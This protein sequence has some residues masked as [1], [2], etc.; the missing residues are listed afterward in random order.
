MN[1][2]TQNNV[3][4][5]V[6]LPTLPYLVPLTLPYPPSGS[7]YRYVYRKSPTAKVELCHNS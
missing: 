1:I 5:I 2:L 3:P 7:I 4:F 6:A